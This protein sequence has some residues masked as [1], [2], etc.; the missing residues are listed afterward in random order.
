MKTKTLVE[1]L[2]MP[3]TLGA[4]SVWREVTVEE[5]QIENF[6]TGDEIAYVSP[7]YK[8]TADGYELVIDRFDGCEIVTVEDGRVYTDAQLRYYLDAEFRTD[9]Y[10]VVNFGQLQIQG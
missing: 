2:G 10:R 5:V 9:Y 7:S 6:R 8:R 4:T 1:H 3:T